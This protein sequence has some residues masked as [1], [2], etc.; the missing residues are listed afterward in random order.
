MYEIKPEDAQLLHLFRT[1]NTYTRPLELNRVLNRLRMGPLAGKFVIVCTTLHKEWAIGQM[2]QKR[3]DAISLHAQRY[4][5]LA[6]AQW[7]LLKIR[8]EAHTP[9]PWP[10]ELD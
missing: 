4:T 8:W 7:H 1:T 10:A 2:G 5:S 6:D 9:Y 3:G